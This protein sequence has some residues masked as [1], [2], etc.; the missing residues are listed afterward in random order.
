MLE[1]DTHLQVCVYMFA[2]E[3]DCWVEFIWSK[4][5]IYK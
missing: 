2:I 1:C 5:K 3:I 4:F